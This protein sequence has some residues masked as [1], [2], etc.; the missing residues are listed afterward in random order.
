M[1]YFDSGVLMK[2]DD[3]LEWQ[4]VAKGATRL[5]LICRPCMILVAASLPEPDKWLEPEGC[6]R[7]PGGP[8]LALRGKGGP[9]YAAGMLGLLEIPSVVTLCGLKATIRIRGGGSL[10]P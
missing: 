2:G 9:F 3:A 4:G 10:K 1:G 8:V 6:T 5:I 7:E